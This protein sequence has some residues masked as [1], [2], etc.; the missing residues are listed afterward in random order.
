M[1]VVHAPTVLS[2]AL[3]AGM[4]LLDLHM[5]QR[6]RFSQMLEQMLE[7]VV[8]LRLGTGSVLPTLEASRVVEVSRNSHGE[9]LRV[10]LRTSF[11]AFVT[12]VLELA[13]QDSPMP[14][15]KPLPNQRL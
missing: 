10:T 4:T 14:L 2:L 11:T 12:S 15:Y 3:G 5:Y 6:H 13:C 9:I 8:A 7:D 1:S